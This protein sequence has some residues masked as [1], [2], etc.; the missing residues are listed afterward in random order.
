MFT[1]EQTERLDEKYQAVEHSMFDLG[2]E[3][4][5]REFMVHGAIV[6]DLDPKLVRDLFGFQEIDRNHCIYKMIFIG[7]ETMNVELEGD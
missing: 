2:A 3:L 6:E 7:Y 4:A 5:H 1:N